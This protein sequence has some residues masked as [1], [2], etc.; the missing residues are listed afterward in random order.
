MLK[1]NAKRRKTKAEA[2][3]E[4]LRQQQ[5]K[6]EIA[7]KLAQFEAMNQKIQELE[8]KCVNGQNAADIL[9]N[10]VNNNQASIDG[11]GNFLV[12]DESSSMI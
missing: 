8:E 10:M 1:A 2:K 11:D 12:N 9:T 3:E 6:E 4:K 7:S 5:E